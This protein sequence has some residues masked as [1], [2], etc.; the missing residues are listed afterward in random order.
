MSEIKFELLFMAA[1][2]NSESIMEKEKRMTIS[3]FRKITALFF[4]LSL[5]AVN[6]VWASQEVNVN[7]A[8]SATIA[9]SLHGIGKSKAK[10]I[11]AY[12][13]AH[14]PF[15]SLDQLAAIKGI[16]EKTLAENAKYIRLK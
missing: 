3:V 7:T 1:M 2:F 13:E 5:V 16:G 4:L 14:G 12:R 11:V 8:D 6:G 15:T 10:A 9:S